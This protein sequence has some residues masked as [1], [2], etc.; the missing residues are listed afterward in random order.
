MNQTWP[1]N[2][3]GKNGDADDDDD[4]DGVIRD[5]MNGI[6]VYRVSLAADA[7][8][9]DAPRATLIYD[10]HYSLHFCASVLMQLHDDND[11]GDGPYLLCDV[12][13]M[14]S[15]MSKW[16]ATATN[17]IK[18]QVQTKDKRLSFTS[19]E[20][21]MFGFMFQHVTNSLW[22]IDKI[23]VRATSQLYGF[24]TIQWWFSLILQFDGKYWLSE[25]GKSTRSHAPKKKN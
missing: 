3:D 7:N 14:T 15:R 22:L 16:N 13:S 25:K 5:Q 6:D 21:K 1:L 8:A 4:G 23:F 19:I 10:F 12:D 2:A 9:N 17:L 18:F 24:M 20:Y 11:C